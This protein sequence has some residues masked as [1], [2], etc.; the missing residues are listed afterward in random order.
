MPIPFNPSS[1][2]LASDNYSLIICHLHEKSMVFLLFLFDLYSYTKK[3]RQVCAVHGINYAANTGDEFNV[4]N[5]VTKY[6][7]TLCTNKTL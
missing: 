7:L 1:V 2:C 5:L 3:Y 6:I 4:V